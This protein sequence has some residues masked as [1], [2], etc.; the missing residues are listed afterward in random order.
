[1][2]YQSQDA[3]AKQVLSTRTDAC[4]IYDIDLYTI[5][6]F[7]VC[8]RCR[9]RCRRSSSFVVVIIVVVV[10]VVVA[11]AVVFVVFVVFVVDVVLM[12]PQCRF[13]RCRDIPTDVAV[14]YC[15]LAGSCVPHPNDENSRDLVLGHE[16]Q[17]V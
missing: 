6:L 14:N 3:G 17:F 9:C 5:A 1:M 11:V 4:A 8:R 7:I 15:T 2:V 13:D 10:V 12:A 16:C